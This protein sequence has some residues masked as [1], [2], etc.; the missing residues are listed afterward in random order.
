MLLYNKT[1]S[2]RSKSTFCEI[3]TWAWTVK[4]FDKITTQ[5]VGNFKSWFITSIMYHIQ[6]YPNQLKKIKEKCKVFISWKQQK[7]SAHSNT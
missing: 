1:D 4:E 5:V 3:S 2:S 7:K 6:M